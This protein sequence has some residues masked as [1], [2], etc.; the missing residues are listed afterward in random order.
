ML[1]ASRER[2]GSFGI[3]SRDLERPSEQLLSA[4]LDNERHGLV[5]QA[6]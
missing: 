1:V 3:S 5:D 6:A 2:L 4:R